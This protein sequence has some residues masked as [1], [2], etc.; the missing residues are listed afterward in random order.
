[1]GALQLL[2][3]HLSL[4]DLAVSTTAYAGAGVGVS[5]LA[6]G[7]IYPFLFASGPAG[8]LAAGAYSVA[9]IAASLYLG[10]KVESGLQRFFKGNESNDQ[11]EATQ[12]GTGR[13]G[14]L[15]KLNFMTPTGEHP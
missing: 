14:V 1:M 15:D 7:L 9:K 12:P 8:W 6:D 4:S 11:G 10:E 3:G 5:L 13:A 2:S